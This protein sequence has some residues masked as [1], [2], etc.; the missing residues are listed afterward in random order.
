MTVRSGDILPFGE[1]LTNA[2]RPPP[3]PVLWKMVDVAVSLAALEHGE[4]GTL[5]LVAPDASDGASIAPGLSLAVQVVRPGEST[6]AH[7][8][9][10]WHVYTVSS[11]RGVAVLGDPRTRSEIEAGDVFLVPAWCKHAFEN[12]QTD[13][14][15]VLTALQNLPEQSY[16]G[17]MVREEADGSLKV[18]YGER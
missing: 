6:S 4:R 2:R 8:H 12:A 10:F 18:V 1:Y 11:G 13:T 16:L 15:L 17:S 14:A 5:A 3:S 7:A 9:S